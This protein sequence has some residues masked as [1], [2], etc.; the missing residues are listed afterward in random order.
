M[1][2]YYSNID[3]S[4]LLHLVVRKEDV[5][6]NRFDVSEEKE[7]LQL[8]VLKFPKDKTFRPHKHVL[9]DAPERKVRT[10]E[11]WA[12]MEGSVRAIFYDLDD[13]ILASPVLRQG[14]ASMT[15]HG[16]HNYVILEDDTVVFE[17][18]TGPFQGVAV[19]KTFL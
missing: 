17:Y 10:Q 5:T 12:I 11:S 4:V 7:F 18:K 2:K 6:D 19:D 13:T 15:F 9:K 16:A 3:P 14:D 1:E 8:A